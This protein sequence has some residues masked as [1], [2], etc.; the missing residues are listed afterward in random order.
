RL[1]RELADWIEAAPDFELLAPLPFATV[2]FRYR[3]PQVDAADDAALER[4]NA[5][6]LERINASGRAFISHTK[7][8]GRQYARRACIGN[9]KT[10]RRHVQRFWELLQSAA[11][12]LPEEMALAAGG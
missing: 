1:A 12:A 11:R 9:L 3:P 5:A 8:R 7:L 4:L 2:V 6:L 10:E